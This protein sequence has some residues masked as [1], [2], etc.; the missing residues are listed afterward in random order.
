MILKPS[1]LLIA[2]LGLIGERVG[3]AN[4][5]DFGSFTPNAVEHRCLGPL[6]KPKPAVSFVDSC[7]LLQ[8]DRSIPWF[9]SH[10]CAAYAAAVDVANENRPPSPAGLDERS[11]ELNHV[12]GVEDHVR[13]VEGVAWLCLHNM[14]QCGGVPG[15]FLREGPIPE[16]K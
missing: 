14:V 11:V 16:V 13:D 8:S 5:L 9:E 1:L 7:V 6:G 10:F 2:S 12:I 4:A 15:Q 3:G